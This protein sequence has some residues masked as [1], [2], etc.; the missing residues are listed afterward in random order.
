MLLTGHKSA[1]SS[2]PRRESINRALRIIPSSN[3]VA[4]TWELGH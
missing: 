1:V 2:H 4:G 3:L